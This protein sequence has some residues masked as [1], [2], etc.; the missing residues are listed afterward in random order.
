VKPTIQMGFGWGNLLH[1]SV[2]KKA[3]AGEKKK[4]GEN[5]RTSPRK[6]KLFGGCVQSG[7]VILGRIAERGEGAG[8]G[9][10]CP[11]R[12]R[13]RE[14]WGGTCSYKRGRR[15]HF[16]GKNSGRRSQTA[17]WSQSWKKQRKSQQ[18]LSTRDVL[19]HLRPSACESGS[20]RGRI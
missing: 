12:S 18:M 5:M 8:V 4:N 3:A 6:S 1:C 11:K 20:K 10:R 13:T 15:K 14:E 2:R 16:R 7:L 9:D 19:C 17:G